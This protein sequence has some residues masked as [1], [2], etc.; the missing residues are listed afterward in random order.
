MGISGVSVAAGST[1]FAALTGILGIFLAV[2][3]SRVKFKFGPDAL[4]RRRISTKVSVPLGLL[5]A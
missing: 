2:Q 1:V 3:A 5:C 4:V